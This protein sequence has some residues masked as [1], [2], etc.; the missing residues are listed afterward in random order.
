[1]AIQVHTH[2]CMGDVIHSLNICHKEL[3]CRINVKLKKNPK[4]GTRISGPI[5]KMEQPSLIFLKNGDFGGL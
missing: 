4:T 1:M 3:D 5:E 2:T